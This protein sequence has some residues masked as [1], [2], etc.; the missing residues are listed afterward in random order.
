[1][2]DE[3]VN[4]SNNVDEGTLD[5]I[6]ELMIKRFDTNV[7]ENNFWVSLINMYDSRGIDRYTGYK[8]LINSITPGKVASFVKGVILAPGNHVEVVM[9]P[10]DL[11]EEGK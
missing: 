3:I 7:K 1:M 6:K 10:E 11:N 8:E 4:V 2:R 5:E 9:M